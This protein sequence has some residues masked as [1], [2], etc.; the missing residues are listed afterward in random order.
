[1]RDLELIVRYIGFQIHIEEYRGD[2]KRFLDFT[3]KRLNDNWD[4]VYL[5]IKRIAR[6]FECVHEAAVDVFGIDQVYRKWNGDTYENRL[7]RAVFDAITFYHRTDQ[8]IER[9][10]SNGPRISDAFKAICEQNY[11]FRNSIET[12]TKSIEAVADRLAMWG[13]TLEALG[14]VDD[15]L[16]LDAERRLNYDPQINIF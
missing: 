5:E 9:L 16:H 13:G 1:M 14:I 7:N 4:K 8:E 10:K 3:V 11:E 6:Q 15:I 12:T 2:L